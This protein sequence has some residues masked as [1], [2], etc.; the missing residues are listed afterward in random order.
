M[1]TVFFCLALGDVHLRSRDVIFRCVIC[2]AGLPKG[3]SR[4]WGSFLQTMY[5]DKRWPLH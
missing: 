4:V 1:Y 5:K 2:T 3:P